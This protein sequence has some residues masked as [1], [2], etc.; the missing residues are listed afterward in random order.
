M[1]KKLNW[2]QENMQIWQEVQWWYWAD[3]FGKQ[4]LTKFKLVDDYSGLT[5]Q[6]TH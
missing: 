5:W 2:L 6:L 1:L 3:E 4:C